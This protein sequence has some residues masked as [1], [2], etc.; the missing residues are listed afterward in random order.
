MFFRPPDSAALVLFGAALLGSLAGCARRPAGASDRLAVVSF[1]NLSSN[2]D[3]DWMRRAVPAV[4]VSDLAGASN[5]DAQMVDSINTAYSIPA[6]RALEAYAVERN[7]RL[8][9]HAA[10]QD[11]N[12]HRTVQSFEVDGPSAGGPLPLANQLAQELSPSARRLQITPAALR[13]FGEALNATD[14]AE[15]LRGFESAVKDSP[16]FSIA[17]LDWAKTLVQAGDREGALKALE[18]GERG[19]ADAID[20]AQLAYTAASIRGDAN[21]RKNA[22]ESLTR[23]LPANP[24]VFQELAA[25]DVSERRFQEAVANYEA[26]VRLDPDEPET[27]NQMGYAQAYQQNLAAA[28][29]ALQ[30]YQELLPQEN[31]N[32]L[33]SLGEVSFF[34]GDFTGAAKYFLDAD[35]KNRGQFGGAELLKAAQARLMAGDLPAADALFQKYSALLSGSR[36][37]YLRAQWEF[38]TG[39]RSEAMAGMEKTIAA[40]AGDDQSVAL[41]QMAIWKLQTGDSKAAR[42]FATQA[43]ARAAG[44]LARS[45]SAACRAIVTAPATA[46]GSPLADAFALLLARQYKQ[47]TPLLEDL[48]R[49]TDP[50]RDGQVRTLLAWA[51][52][53][54]NRITDADRLLR[55]FPIPLSSGESVFASLVFPRFV[56]L[57]AEVFEQQGKRAEAKSAYQL[58]L[59]YAG[60]VPDVFGDEIIARQNLG[61]L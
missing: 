58:F 60:D 39:R 43:A 50:S 37:A 45:L 8:E 26:A 21:A 2:L 3:L 6:S 19:T 33:D 20:R 24:K 57:R 1:E 38:L 56:L 40:L 17:Y 13:S 55:I 18:A 15:A 29:A 47:A 31:A 25:L 49:R 52:L 28:R 10:L 12:S 41:S 4:V 23:L 48:L 61:R 11:L 14:R 7:G 35:Q 34:L 27:W 5:M 36:A 53:R 44:P 46:S 51:Y 16:A 54:T 9:I 42:D 22:L 32:S 30:H 59:K